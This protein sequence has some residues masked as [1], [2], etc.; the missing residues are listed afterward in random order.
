MPTREYLETARTLRRAAQRM[1]DRIIAG[2]LSALAED[3]ERRAE[4]AAE[5]NAAIASAREGPHSLSQTSRSRARLQA[6]RAAQLAERALET[7]QD[8]G[9][10]LQEHAQRKHKLTK[11]PSEFRENR[12]DQPG[13][14]LPG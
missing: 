7:I 11:G 3:C 14:I 12:I 9:G 10:P 8:P 4:K 13:D 6:V 2:R 1:T 5:A